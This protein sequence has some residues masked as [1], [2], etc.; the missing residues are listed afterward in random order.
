MAVLSQHSIG[1]A[2][3]ENIDLLM[4]VIKYKKIFFSTNYAQYDL[5]LQGKFKFFPDKSH[6]MSLHSDYNQ[7]IQAGMFSQTP[8]S[9]EQIVTLLKKLQESINEN[10]IPMS[11]NF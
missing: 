10:L 6:I 2:A 5:C 9:F 11:L 8:L 4:D 7:M 3:I 1:Q